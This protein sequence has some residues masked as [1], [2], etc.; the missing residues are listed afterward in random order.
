VVIE[1][2][3]RVI[4][5]EFLRNPLKFKLLAGDPCE[6]DGYALL[7][8]LE[9]ILIHLL[10]E[11]F[12]SHDTEGEIFEFSRLATYHFLHPSP[13]YANKECTWYSNQCILIS[14]RLPTNFYQLLQNSCYLDTILMIILGGDASSW[15]ETIFTEDVN[16][17]DYVHFLSAFP[18]AA[19][20]ERVRS[21]A[22]QLQTSLFDDYSAIFSN[23]TIGSLT[24]TS[25]RECF[26][27]ILPDMKLGGAWAPFESSIIYDLLADF[28]PGLKTQCPVRIV[29]DGA[30][31]SFQKRPRNLLQMWD[32]MD[33]LTDTEGSY[34]EILWDEI[35]S[36][37]LVFQ[38]GCL[39]PIR[40]FDSLR[41]ED[42]VTD[43]T[44]KIV[45]KRRAFGETILQGRYR[46]SGVVTLVGGGHYIGYIR[47]A[48]T[49]YYYNDSGPEFRELP[50]LPRIG[51]WQESHGAKPD[52]LFYFLVEK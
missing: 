23:S 49:W 45:H 38:N 47:A 34:E 10:V 31:S 9:H 32:Y 48:G 43:N 20:I 13:P 1:V 11:V 15:R 52:L 22:Y 35:D 50:S 46:L 42:V 12:A 41:P 40:E 3:P 26:A 5:S 24:S 37:M 36:P 8:I 21:V 25:I 30:P 4:S 18:K 7:F 16:H 33:P 28:F 17:T 19:S 27:S 51:V 39:P 6:T 29:K 14:L 2:A 44:R